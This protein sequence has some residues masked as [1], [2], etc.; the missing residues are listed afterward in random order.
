MADNRAESVFYAVPPN[1][2]PNRDDQTEAL[3]RQRQ[4]RGLRQLLEDHGGRVLS[5]LRKQLCPPLDSTALDVALNTAAHRAWH[6]IH[7]F[8]P[9][10]GSLPAW[11]LIVTRNCALREL[12]REAKHRALELNDWDQSL[13]HSDEPMAEPMPSRF[14]AD[15]RRCVAD[16]PPKQRAVIEADLA[17][18]GD[19]ENAAVL[20]K[21][22]GTSTNSIYVTR[23]VARK[24]LKSALQGLGYYRDIP[25]SRNR[26]GR[27]S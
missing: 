16:L 22:L 20:A 10:R 14:L 13:V 9:K 4:E 12:E 21:Q 15:V 27:E 23:N 7:T 25:I 17:A 24:K 19:V 18:V 1:G 26:S 2:R 5:V 11:F 3:L 8:D 6:S